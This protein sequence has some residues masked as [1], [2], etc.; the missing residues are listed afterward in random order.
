M[1]S[2]ISEPMAAQL[3]GWLRP[4]ITD[5]DDAVMAARGYIALDGA[6]PLLR[7]LGIEVVG[8]APGVLVTDLDRPVGEIR[9]MAGGEG[10]VIALDN[11]SWQ[12]SCVASI[13]MLGDR[14]LFVLNDCG[15][16]GFVRINEMLLRSDDQLVFWGAG[17]TAVGVSI[18]LE[19]SGRSC[20]IGDD[21]LIS[22]DVWIRNYDMH[23]IHDLRSG[24]Q[25]NRAACD[26]V[27]E[28]HVW[29]GQDALLLSCE[30][31]GR[32]SIVGA[33]AMVKGFVPD[34]SVAAGVPARVLRQGISWGRSSLGMSAEERARLGLTA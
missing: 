17:A 23:A 34:L 8:G 7:Q 28:R 22:N 21:A 25:I 6:D 4:E 33:R 5:I 1:F 26:T 18:E 27:L 24:G 3:R 12:G 11:A 16:E 2:L 10:N 29:L 32:G 20:V 15:A 9:V 19:G 14:G 13:R 31:V 30:R